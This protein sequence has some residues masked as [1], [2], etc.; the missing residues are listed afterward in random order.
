MQRRKERLNEV[1]DL[2]AR[3]VRFIETFYGSMG[4][5][6]SFQDRDVLI[7]YLEE[8]FAPKDE[9]HYSNERAFYY[10]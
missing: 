6:I 9:K 1:I 8:K 7:N 4:W 3:G 10:E 2:S 5:K